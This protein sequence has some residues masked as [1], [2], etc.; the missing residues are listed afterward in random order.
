[1]RTNYTIIGDIYHSYTNAD[2]GP[3]DKSSLFIRMALNATSITTVRQRNH[4]VDANI[5]LTH[6]CISLRLV[7]LHDK[8]MFSLAGLQRHEWS[9]ELMKISMLDL[10]YHTLDWMNNVMFL[11]ISFRLNKKNYVSARY[12]HGH[13]LKTY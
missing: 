9:Q 12:L 1:M 8:F 2:T 5:S 6:W 7:L 3:A 13:V 11:L 4:D 10:M